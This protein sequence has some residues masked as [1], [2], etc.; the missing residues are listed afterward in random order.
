MQSYLDLMR[1]VLHHGEKRMDRTGTGTLSIFDTRLKFN[2]GNGFPALTTKRVFMKGVW[3]ELIMF[4]RGSDNIQELWDQNVHIWDEWAKTDGDVGPI[5]GVQWRN[6]PRFTWTGAEHLVHRHDGI[7]NPDG[8][9]QLAGVIHAINNTPTSR[10]LLVTAWNPSELADMALP[11]CHYAFQFYVRNG[12]HLDCKVIMRSVDVFLGMP[13]DI[14]SYATL[15]HMIGHVT[16]LKAGWLTMDF[17][18][19]HI[20]LNHIE[21]VKQQLKR[22]PSVLPT[23]NVNRHNRDITSIDDFVI[24]DFALFDY[25]PQPGIKGD[26]SK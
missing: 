17:G 18:D 11:P 10:R 20:Y 23:L 9:D 24:S 14:A 25:Y 7:G 16:N 2:L 6:W 15:V 4:L 1:Y 26:I 21:Q 5:Y 19:T 3:A 13:F 22:E 8:I 12:T